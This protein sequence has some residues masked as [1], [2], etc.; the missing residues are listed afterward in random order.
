MV[1]KKKPNCAL[2]SKISKITHL[3]IFLSLTRTLTN[4]IKLLLFCKMNIC[5]YKN[6]ILHNI[7]LSVI[8]ALLS[9]TLRVSVIQALC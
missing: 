4:K 6:V 5:M 3:N 8:K 9:S 2:L 7:S 1:R